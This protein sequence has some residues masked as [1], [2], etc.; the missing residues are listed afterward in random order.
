LNGVTRDDMSSNPTDPAL[1]ALIG[2]AVNHQ[3]RGD[4]AAAE[5]L[6]TEVLAKEPDQADAQHFMGLLAHQ[7]GRDGLAERHLLRALEIAPQRADFHFNYAN[8][9]LETSRPQLAAQS[10][11]RA[12]DL[13]PNMI[14]AWWGLGQTLFGLDHHLH[15]AVCLQRVVELAPDR[16]E[17][18]D[19]LGRCL[20]ALTLLPEA[21]EAFRRALKLAPRE[22]ELQLALVTTLMEDHQD[23]EAEQA[24]EDLLSLAPEM[25]EAHYQRGVWS[26]NKGDF[27]GA[28]ASLER[29]LELR[30]SYYQAAL[31]YTYVTPLPPDDPLV[32]RL[33][34]R[35]KEGGWD[36]AGQGANV[37]F[38][39]GYVFDKAKRYDE[40]FQHY[41]EANRL[42]RSLIVYSTDAQRK[43]QDSMQ[44]V[45]GPAF[46]ARAARFGSPS[47][48]PLFIVGM[49]RSGT[50]LLEQI[51]TSHPEVYGGGEMTFL[52]AEL[53]RRMGPRLMGDFAGAVMA[54][55]DTEWAE[56]GASLLAHLDRLAP[57]ARRVTDKM[58]SNFMMLGLLRGLFPKAR[59]IHCRRDPLDT[60]ISCFTTSF[61]QGHKFTND[62]RELGEYYRLYQEAMAY[63]R[64]VLP[65]HVF[66]EVDYENLVSDMESEVRKLLAFSGLEWDPKCLDFQQN[67]RAVS[68]ASVYQVR[69]PIY[70][71]AIGRWKRYAAHL[72][73]LLEALQM[74]GLV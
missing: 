31:Y 57:S 14:D 42:Q 9:L 70:A 39:L 33:L 61:K 56:L 45:Y 35:A 53:R 74:P 26:A 30:P 27:V 55:S 38:A 63:W 72:G 37:H 24:L 40:A 47:E 32:T 68:T 36:G 71:T 44:Q 4:Y 22:P 73:P 54:F 29:A 11:Q 3:Q 10:F 62:L 21:T 16:A 25:P 67:Q 51:L 13:S 66:Y 65:A 12:V 7:T 50:S 8:M 49:P 59:I 60:C 28:R 48:K 46:I 18:W 34:Q 20:Q 1:R 17:A 15:A 52:H 23:A 58:P 2:R 69:Q 41:L 19:A 6:Y 64:Q 5:R 43:L